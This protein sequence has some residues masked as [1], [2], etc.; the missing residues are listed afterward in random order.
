MPIP[1]WLTR[2]FMHTFYDSQTLY[3][4]DVKTLCGPYWLT[5]AVITYY[6]L[7]L[8]NDKFPNEK[9]NM[10]FIP[11]A[12]TFWASM[13]D[14]AS[15]AV[16]PLELEKK[17]LIFI[18]INDSESDTGGGSHWS[19]V[20]YDREI[21]TF[22]YYDS[23]GTHNL[24]A[25]RRMVRKLAPHVGTKNVSKPKFDVRPSPQ[26]NN[27]FDCGVHVLAVTDNLAQ[28]HG[29]DDHLSNNINSHT[30]SEL[31]KTMLENIGQQA[32]KK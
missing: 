15:D 14:D 25:A 26:Q 29:S 16:G 4:D 22:N 18:P 12:I 2:E 28:N 6:Y 20:I 1:Q 21:D 3:Y 19:L 24:S 31:R 5:D 8:E 23:M 10:C 7:L 9:N 11:P 32:Q 17:N 27:G 30:I 13:V